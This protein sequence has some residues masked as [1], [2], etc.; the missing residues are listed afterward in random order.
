MK[1]N[2]FL[3]CSR[4]DY[5]IGTVECLIDEFLDLQ[6]H[7]IHVLNDL[8]NKKRVDI[9]LVDFLAS[10]GQFKRLNNDASNI[11]LPKVYVDSSFSA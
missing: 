9:P 3:K 8:F 11:M 4:D 7:R 10:T 1:C 6:V 2:I 5:F